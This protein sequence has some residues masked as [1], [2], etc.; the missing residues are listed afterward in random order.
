M[1]QLHIANT[2]TDLIQGDV[3]EHLPLE[4]IPLQGDVL[5]LGTTS[6]WDNGELAFLCDDPALV[7][8]GGRPEPATAS[9]RVYKSQPQ[10]GSLLAMEPG[11]GLQHFPY[12]C[13]TDDATA[14]R[15]R[16]P[17]DLLRNAA[18]RPLQA[19]IAEAIAA[20]TADGTLEPSPVYGLRLLSRWESLVITV[21]SKLCLGQLRRNQGLAKMEA[22]GGEGASVGSSIYDRLP[23]FRLSAAD[24]A[25]PADPI[26][27]LG[28]DSRRWECC[29]FFDTQPTLGRLTVPVEGAHLHLHGCSCDLRHGGHLHHEHAGSRLAALEWLVLYPLNRLAAMGS[30]LAVGDLSY[31]AGELGFTLSNRGNLDASDIGVAVVINDRYGSHRYL[32]LPWLAAGAAER[33]SMPLELPPGDHKLEVIADPQGRILE[34]EVRRANN[35]ASLVISQ[36]T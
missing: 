30:D 4:R 21:A 17:K 19:L 20:M 2:V 5:G 14:L 31:S 27:W 1:V 34:E 26:R 23:H 25:D 24:P 7:E 8:A 28:S 11:T 9:T 10:D 6:G 15:R 29:G 35:R 18:G 33:V 16:V 13:F 22:L 3:Q 36:P 32:H 12:V